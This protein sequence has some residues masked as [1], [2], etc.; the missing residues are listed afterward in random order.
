M[1]DVNRNRVSR[2]SASLALS[3]S[4]RVFFARGGTARAPWR[5][6]FA[7][8][9]T[10]YLHLGHVAN[11]IHV[12]GIARAYGGQV[13]LRIEDHDPTRS[14][15][16]YESALLDDL[17]WLEL[18]PDVGRTEHF[19]ISNTAFRQSDN[20]QA[21]NSA[22]QALAASGATYRCE[23][24]RKEIS[25]HSIGAQE[26]EI[27][28]PG[29]CANL[30]LDAAPVQAVRVRVTAECEQFADLRLGA[31]RQ[32]PRDQCGDFVICDRNGNFTYQFAVAVD[33]WQQDIDVIIRGEDLL[34]STGR[35][36]QLARMLGRNSPPTFIHHQLIL[37]E[38]GIKLSKS[39][40]DAG[41]REM[42]A[43]GLSSR[44]VLGRA[45]FASGL[46][47]VET[48]LAAA[49]LKFLFD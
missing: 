36:L 17:D 26:G 4:L 44:D 46:I 2:T 28:Y 45:A 24:S 5:T 11:A 21:Y 27:R 31:Q 37:R 39:L 15:P 49:D 43:A 1:L 25:R 9:P 20:L 30:S 34:S 22:F 23:C 18:E 48:P 16:E 40:G 8:A 12:W 42:R 32:C 14:R 3:N 6:R 7:P 19:R 29:T 47:D 10:G 38:D 41:V 33:D 35:Q 13:V